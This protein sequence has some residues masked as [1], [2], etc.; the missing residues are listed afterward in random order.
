MM[1]LRFFLLFAP[2]L[3]IQ[4]AGIAQTICNTPGQNPTSAF[5]VCGTGTFIQTS[6]NLCGG[7]TLP[8]PTC[9][10]AYDDRNPYYYKFTCF[11]AGTLGLLITPNANSSDYDWQIFDITGRQPNDIFSVASL[12]VSSNWS[13]NPG[14][15]GTNGTANGQ[16]ECGGNTPNFSRWPTLVKDHEYLLMISHF[17]NN[18]AGYKLEFKGGTAVITDT[19]RP[20]MQAIQA[21]CSGSQFYLKLN[22]PVKCLSIA[23]NGSDWELVNSTIPISAAA[24][25][26][27]TSGFDTDSIMIT[28]ASRL[29]PGTYTIRSR[30][31]TDGNTLLDFCDNAMTTGQ[32]LTVNV[33]PPAP[34]LPDSFSMQG[35]RP[36][37]LELVMDGPVSCSSIA[38]DG[39]DFTI[40]GPAPVAIV[41]A[42]QANCRQGEVKTIR[43]Q[44]ARAITIG[45]SY[46][47]FL[48]KG[49]DG[50]SLLNACNVESPVGSFATFTGYDTVSAKIDIVVKSSCQADTITYSNPIANNAN[51]WSWTEQGTNQTAHTPDFRRIYNTTGEARVLLSVSNGICRDSAVAV[52]NLS[53]FRV[54]AAFEFP[55]YACPLDTIRFVDKS[56][57]P[58]ASWS[59]NFGNGNSSNLQVPPIQFYSGVSL[60]T[61]VPVSLVVSQ[62][63]GCRDSVTH[64]INVPDNCYIAV[65]NAFTP[66]GDGLNDFLYPLNAWKATNLLFRVQNRYGQLVWETTDWTRKWDGRI[67]GIQAPAGTFVWLLQYIEA[68]T[69]K[70]VLLKG[71]TTLIR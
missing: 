49:T 52:V 47:V 45:G 57:G 5:P 50:N 46:T 68:D 35:C 36:L 69:G 62:A 18:Q 53:N 8:N 17:S 38:A 22:K 39:S 3:T 28:T 71:T 14:Q 43:I 10:S 59:W 41:G 32:Q 40:D 2:I 37:E 11:Q 70:K 23:G 9:G 63:N 7:R 65:P 56:S 34:A 48:K 13:G 55:D 26:N 16:H 29:P 19:A 6:V 31:G 44:L 60:V 20:K 1:I 54:H 42:I 25:I 51:R 33:L 58:V 27:C 4:S 24:G 21:A 64:L 12:V 67:G 66:N 15:T 30:N 61:K